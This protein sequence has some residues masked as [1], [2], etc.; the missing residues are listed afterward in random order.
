MTYL[1]SIVKKRL[2]DKLSKLSKLRPLPKSA[3]E[4]LKDKFQ[5]EMTYNSNAIEGNSL[6]LKETFLVINEGLTVKG[7]P[8]KDHLEAKDH[9]AALE[10]LYEL[11]EMNKKHTL[12][13]MLIRNLHQIIIQETDKEWAGKYRNANVVIGGAKHT[14]PEALE[15]P[16]KMRDLIKWLSSQKNKT[17]IVEL[18]A[19]LHH[20]LVHIHPFFDGNGRT[21][22]LAMNLLLMQAGYPLVVILKNDR[23]KYYDVLGKADGGRYEPL[24]KFIAQ[25]VERSLDIYL[26]TLTP[27]SQ[28]QEK[29][30]TFA[31][32]AK[33]TPFSA[34]YLNLLARQG[35]LEAYKEGRNWLTSKEAIERYLKNRARKRKVGK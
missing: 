14:P 1:S 34:K 12:S 6:T 21:S 7:K 33:D 15:V 23:K 20:K 16:Q 3:V 8:L 5:I 10:Y 32:I 19:L 2:E 35:K 4:K 31:E 29:F 13:E 30:L 26:K 18:S 17:H 11:I 22:R 24:I 28:K 9:Y 27:A 25:G